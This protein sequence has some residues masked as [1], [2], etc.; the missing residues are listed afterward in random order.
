VILADGSVGKHTHE[1]LKLK[2]LM[3]SE[4][5]LMAS[6]RLPHQVRTHQLSML[7]LGNRAPYSTGRRDMEHDGG[8]RLA[9]VDEVDRVREVLWQH[10][11]LIYGSFDYYA[12]LYSEGQTAEGEPDI[13]N[14]SFNAFLRFMD[15]CQLVSK[16]V[17]KGEFQTVWVAVNAV[18]KATA[19]EDEFNSKSALNRQEWLQVLVRCAILLYSKRDVSESVNELLTHNLLRLLP[20][21]ALQN[22]NAFRKRFCYLEAPTMVLE[23]HR[24][25][26]FALY[27][28]YAQVSHGMQDRLKDDS[29]MSIGEWLTF[30]RHVG[31]VESGQV[32]E[33]A[34][35]QIFLWSRI[36]TAKD[37]SGASEAKLRH[38]TPTDFLEALVR[39]SLVVALPTDLEL[40]EANAADAGEFLLAMQTHSPIE[41]QSFLSTH[42]P[43]HQDHDG[44]DYAAHALQPSERC[45]EHL[46][47]LIV[48]TVQTNTSHSASKDIL[49]LDRTVEDSE[50]AKF[51]KRRQQN[52]S[53]ARFESNDALSKLNFSET[54]TSAAAKKMQTAAAIMIQLL[55]RARKARKEVRE[56]RLRADVP[57]LT[58]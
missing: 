42:R 15:Q 39:L 38:I 18:D 5:M 43:R 1:L 31:L 8:G 55:L 11:R 41:Y 34:A 57:S 44:S 36:R 19:D 28:A 22:S 12:S 20:P 48:R 37:L 58:T 54:L 50:A 53:L 33:L 14:M 35:K 45:L 27:N 10:H 21:A 17:S 32:T 24:Q 3:T 2:T 4:W 40:E 16:D 46:I 52:I 30:V 51:L 29:L 7:I 47:K 23:S 25:S 9:E 49:A 56:R 13:Y 26:L 6:E